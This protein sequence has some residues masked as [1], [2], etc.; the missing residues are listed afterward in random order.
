MEIITFSPERCRF[1]P[2]AVHVLRPQGGA[3]SMAV[4]PGLVVSVDELAAV[5]HLGN[6]GLLGLLMND[7]Q[8]ATS[9]ISCSH[10]QQNI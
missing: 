4:Y 9:I 3:P 5:A 10:K 2:Q 8:W 6:L 7:F 1:H